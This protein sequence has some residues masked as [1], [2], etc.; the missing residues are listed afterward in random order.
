MKRFSRLLS[1]FMLILLFSCSFEYEE[2]SVKTRDIVDTVGFAF[3]A[4]QMDSIMNRIKKN[5]GELLQEA[6]LKAGV[7]DSIVWKAAISPHDDYTYAGYSY[8][9]ALSNI[10]ANTLIIFGVAHK[11]KKLGLENKIVFDSY[12]YWKGPYGPIPVSGLRD[13]I[14]AELPADI[15]EINNTM[16]SIEHSVEALLPFLQYYNRNIEI[17]SILV[18]YMSFER[19]KEIAVPLAKAI[20][21]ATG[22]TKLEW[23][24]G[25][26]L[27]FSSDA[28]HYGD[29]NWSG[30]NYAP[31]GADVEGYEQALEKEWGILNSCFSGIMSTEKIK[32]FTGHTVS[33][34]DYHD[35]IWTWCGRYSVP[36]GLL[37]ALEIQ[38]MEAI[39]DIKGVP[40]TYWTSISGK[41]IMVDDLGL[42]KTAPADIRH[43]V[44]Y[45]AVGFY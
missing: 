29:K 33:K 16:Q 10:R 5:Q 12:G 8:L 42:G 18:P 14:I 32:K 30:E 21:V 19:M 44:G 41:H 40:V 11:A 6:F 4:R 24:A 34:E 45:P 27:L 37:T 28:V 15:Y 1:F 35:Y 23:G 25:Y 26:A 36:M 13:S 3:E 7:N 43:W 31:F 17:I 22:K 2:T 9:A 38:K 20:E 39:S